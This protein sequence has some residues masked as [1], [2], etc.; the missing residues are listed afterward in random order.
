MIMTMMILQICATKSQVNQ[1]INVLIHDSDE[2]SASDENDYSI[3]SKNQ[4]NLEINVFSLTVRNQ[5]VTE[6]IVHI[7]ARNNQIKLNVNVSELIMVMR[8]LRVTLR[9]ILLYQQT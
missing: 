4:A 1:D 6:I 8:C 5:K 2:E 9:C 7:I 3:A